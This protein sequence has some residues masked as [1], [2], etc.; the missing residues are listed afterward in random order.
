MHLYVS[1]CDWYVL[2]LGEHLISCV[3]LISLFVQQ[4]SVEDVSS[5]QLAWEMLEL[6]KVIYRRSA[7]FCIV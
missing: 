5:L 4:E 1:A 6:A 3:V 7:R 2:H